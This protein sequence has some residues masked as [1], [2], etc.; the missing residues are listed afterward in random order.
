[1]ERLSKLTQIISIL[2][3]L[4]SLTNS[5]GIWRYCSLK[6]LGKIGR[7]FNANAVGN[8]AYGMA[9]RKHDGGFLKFVS[10]DEFIAR[11]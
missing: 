9:C 10:F 4:L 2:N 3:Q 7:R 1:M 8:L 6:T 11:M 5:D